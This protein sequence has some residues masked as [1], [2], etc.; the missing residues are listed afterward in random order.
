MKRLTSLCAALLLLVSAVYAQEQPAADDPIG[1][2]AATL[3]AELGK[4]KDTTPEA[5]EAMA[6]LVDLYH[7]DGRL[8]GLVRIA[9]QFAAAHPTDPRHKGV[10][11]KLID[12]QEALSRNKEL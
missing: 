8:F 1:K 11:L 9:Q 5:A 3:E 6:K 2:Q 4:F 7:A 10:M 12:G